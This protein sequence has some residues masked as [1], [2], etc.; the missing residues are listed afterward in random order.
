M[1]RESTR[2]KLDRVRSPRV[3]ISYEVKLGDAIE[4]REVPFVI[5]V[6]GD[7]S[8]AAE[9]PPF[10]ERKFRRVDFD[11]FNDVLAE[12]S[13]RTCFKISSSLTGGELDV[14]L[15]FRAIEDFQP[16]N[17]IDQLA[18]LD[19]LRR[20]N[21][22]EAAEEIARHLDRVLHA[23]EF[24]ALE[25]AWRSLWYLVSRT[26]ISSRSQIKLLDV[27]KNELLNDLQRAP[28]FDQSRLFKAVY[29]EPYGTFGADAEPF[30]LLGEPE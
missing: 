30:G 5:G 17:V 8:G 18:L 24:Q 1:A 7:Y 10:R 19:P 6:M 23:P 4:D 9:R 25:S 15:T 13:P 11:R 20:S 26:E 3:L 29:E 14:D 21:S 22:P 28:D 16:E 2:H 27:T 12:L